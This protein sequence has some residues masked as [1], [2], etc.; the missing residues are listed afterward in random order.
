MSGRGKGMDSK[1][2]FR[3]GELWSETLRSGCPERSP[4]HRS[5]H[6]QGTWTPSLNPK[7][8]KGRA[9]FSYPNNK[10]FST[11]LADANIRLGRTKRLFRIKMGALKS[12]FERVD[13]NMNGLVTP[14]EVYRGLEEAKMELPAKYVEYLIRRCMYGNSGMT[15]NVGDCTD[16]YWRAITLELGKIKFDAKDGLDEVELSQL[17]QEFSHIFDTNGDGNV[18]AEEVN[19]LFKS[20]DKDGSG[21]LSYRE[22]TRVMKSLGTPRGIDGGLPPEPLSMSLST[23]RKF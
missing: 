14:Q 13:K 7:P 3:E 20:F 22:L 12:Y 16:V 6:S 11:P 10:Q 1:V 9:E 18:E 5:F 4:F 15:P 21:S 23:T 19:A 17:A 2:S 8:M